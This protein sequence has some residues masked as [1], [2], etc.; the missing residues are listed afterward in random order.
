M[1]K[2]NIS[3]NKLKE[4]IEKIGLLVWLCLLPAFWSL[5]YQ[6]WLI[7]CIFCWLQQ[8]ISTSLG[9]IFR[10][11]WKVLF[12]SFRKCYGLLGS[13][14]PLARCQHLKIQCFGILLLSQHFFFDISSHNISQTVK[15]KAPINHIIFCKNSIRYS[16]CT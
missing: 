14:L 9:K 11:I 16:R 10:C 13:E 5:K 7:F 4:L 8:K 1:Q 2:W 6:N 3:T 15:S 12:S